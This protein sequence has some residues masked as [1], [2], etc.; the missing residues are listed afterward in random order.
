MWL[1]FLIVTVLVALL[2]GGIGLYKLQQYQRFQT[3][4]AAERPAVV[5]SSAPVV[6]EQWPIEIEA[7]GTFMANQGVQV[8]TEVPGR[9][10]RIHFRSGGHVAA[11]ELLL[12]LDAS[13]ERAELRALEADLELARLDLKRVE[14]LRQTQAVS[15]SQLDRAATL[16]RSLEARAEQHAVLIERKT[17]RAPFDGDLGIR[18]V[19]LGQYLSPGDTVVSLQALDPMH[20]DFTLPERYLGATGVGQTVRAP[21]AAWPDTT[22]AGTITA[23]SPEL[24]RA[25]RMLH[26]QATLPNPE[27]R[28]RPGM[29]SQLTVVVG[30]PQPVLTLPRT[31]VAYQAFGETVFVLERDADGRLTAEQRPVR[32][33]RV[34]AGRV[35]ILEGV[36][37]DAEV[38]ATGQM[39]L[40][41]GQRVRI[42]N[43]LELP[44]GVALR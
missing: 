18:L 14:D 5:V 7:L 9:V 29:F 32:V 11:G 23:I 28:L 24:Q 19:H 35:E 13:A 37:E 40:R 2:F 44:S 34:R 17:I 43:S 15:Q 22:F 3:M 12:E 20:L 1:R 33:G 10:Q 21:V 38:V 42:D 26:L 16:V 25:T 27:G 30:D 41:S 36:A 8:A 31:A 39:K 6:L 4:M